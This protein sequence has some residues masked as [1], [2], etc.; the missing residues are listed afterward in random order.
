MSFRSSI[1]LAVSAFALAV[2][3]RPAAAD[4]IVRAGDVLEIDVAGLSSLRQKLPVSVDGTVRVPIIGPVTADGRT[5]TE[6]TETIQARLG[7]KTLR[8][9][10]PAGQDFQLF[11]EPE[12]VQVFISEYRPVYV[13][14]DVGRPGQQPY[15]P[16]MTV[17]Q[18]IALAGGYDI[19]RNRTFDPF[20]QIADLSAELNALRLEVARDEIQIQRIK[21]ELEG[22]TKAPAFAT[23]EIGHAP[24]Q[25]ADV[26]RLEMERFL[27]N[28]A[29]HAKER[30]YLKA[31]IESTAAQS[32]TLND[33]LQREKEGLTAEL[34]EGDRLTELAKNGNTTS[35]RVFEARR[36][37]LFASARYLQTVAQVTQLRRDRADLNRQL[38]K[39]G[40]TRRAALL[41]ELQDAVIRT[42]VASGKIKSAME[43][44]A[45][46]TGA[47]VSLQRRETQPPTVV[48]V[49]Q[50]DGRAQKILADEDMKLMPGDVVEAMLRPLSQQGQPVHTE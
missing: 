30:S 23:A 20:L 22:E 40:G 14:G 4:Y 21:S 29:D 36:S 34:Q 41:K 27:V 47:K 50:T 32:E 6:I 35:A 31:A 26:A 5:L 25:Q 1:R 12:Q 17:R 33:Q 3:A 49:R 38:D 15:R 9:T 28:V 44:L 24:V 8:Q 46:A 13:S 45:Y 18:S 11:F 7:N 16:G 48:I 10:S 37:I 42:D 19:V 43:K 39:L 2:P